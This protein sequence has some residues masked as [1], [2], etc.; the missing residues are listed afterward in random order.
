MWVVDE[1]LILRKWPVVTMETIALMVP[2][3]RQEPLRD[4][5]YPNTW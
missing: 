4:R 2:F 1:Q 5:I 3:N